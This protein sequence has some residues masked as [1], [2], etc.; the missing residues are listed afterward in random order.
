MGAIFTK[1]DD[2]FPEHED[3]VTAYRF[4]QNSL[5]LGVDTFTHKEMLSKL[6]SSGV[7][8]IGYVKLKFIIM[9]FKEM[10]ILQIDEFEDDVNE[11][12]KVFALTKDEWSGRQLPVYGKTR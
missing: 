5:H 3:F 8:G 9:V 1:N 2:Y 12:T 4:L 6:A 11:I 10:N 7:S